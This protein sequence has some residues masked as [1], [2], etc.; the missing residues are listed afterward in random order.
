MQLGPFSLDDV[1]ARLASGEVTAANLVLVW[2]EGMPEWVPIGSVG[3]FAAKPPQGPLAPNV[4][5]S[6][7][8]TLHDIATR[9]GLGFE[10][11]NDSG[12]K[13]RFEYGALGENFVS[14]VLREGDEYDGRYCAAFI[15]PCHEFPKGASDP[16]CIAFLRANVFLPSGFSFC[17]VETGVLDVLAVKSAM[18]LESMS[19][20]EFRRVAEHL[21]VFVDQ[22]RETL[23]EVLEKV[24]AGSV[25]QL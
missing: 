11:V 1:K 20:K 18:V 13:V 23:K 25:D 19:P 6:P 9:S 10:Q 8:A 24:V 12:L 21:V 2:K 14:V 7:I 3:D 16:F 22:Y 4:A 15:C 5:L 17:L